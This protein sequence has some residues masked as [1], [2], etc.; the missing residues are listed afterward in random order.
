MSV[1]TGTVRSVS[2]AANPT[3]VNPVSPGTAN[4]EFSQALTGNIKQFMIRAR[5]RNAKVQIAFNTGESGTT[6]F[7]IEKGAV[8]SIDN[9]NAISP[10]IY[11]QTNK[12]SVTIEIMYWT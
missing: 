8:L 7:T 11:M 12:T 1:A 9:I 6:F 2:P 4:T 3:I 5:E 10:T